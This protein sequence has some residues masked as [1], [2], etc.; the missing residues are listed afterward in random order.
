MH[1]A[2]GNALRSGERPAYECRI[3]QA[4]RG[5]SHFCDHHAS[6]YLRRMVDCD[7][8]EGA[9]Q[10]VRDLPARQ[11]VA[12]YGFADSICGLRGLAAK[13]A[14]GGGTGAAGLLLA[15]AIGGRAASS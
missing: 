5:R 8:L 9:D 1:R 2:N 12:V 13:L 7:L 4:W 11:A 15:V 14:A 6:Y 3:N 10:P